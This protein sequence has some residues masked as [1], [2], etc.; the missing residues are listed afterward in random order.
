MASPNITAL[1]G[2]L[3]ARCKTLLNN[4]LK[5]ICKEE[6]LGVSGV[7]AQLQTKVMGLIETASQQNDTELLNRLRHRILNH[8]DAPPANYAAPTSPA[9]AH[10]GAS[11]AGGFN[12]ASGYR[13]NQGYSP[14]QQ[15]QVPQYH[16]R[17]SPFYEIR[18]L[19]LGEMTLEISPNHRQNINRPL[20][21]PAEMCTQLKADPTLRLLLLAGLEQPLAAYTRIDISFP[22]QVEV[23]INGDEVK[24]NFKGLKNKPGSTRP[25][26]ITDYVRKQAQY[27]NS[28]IVTYA[29]TQKKFNLY[30]YLAKK[31]SVED[32][33]AR[34]AKRNVI[35]KQT[36]ISEMRKRASDQ[37]V[38]VDSIN[39][40]LKDPI[41]TLRIT[42]PCRSNICSHN[43][44]F[45]VESFLQLQEQA[46][47]WQCPICNKTISFE[48]LAVDQYVE[49]ILENVPKGTDQVTIE[50]N[51]NWT[52]TPKNDS[53]S[54]RNGYGAADDDE[55]DYELVEII[56]DYR[57][58]AIKH[59]AMHTPKS[60]T[61]TPSTASR[62]VSTAPRAGSKRTSE[63]IDLTL[64]DDDEPVRPAKK[65]AYSTPN[66]LP[67][68]SR[69]YTLPSFGSSS[70]PMRP[71]TQAPTSNGVSS[72]ILRYDQPPPPPT[73]T[74]PPQGHAN[75]EAYA[76]PRP[77]P[78]PNYY[79]QGTQQYP[80]YLGSSP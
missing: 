40:S 16:F 59:E 27:R 2:T 74:L 11:A 80:Q 18:S 51:G 33:T 67:D 9:V 50:P 38:V 79:G 7:K 73:P 63:V 13:A 41:S 5:K 43:Q 77:P 32:L 56:S 71:Q 34:I 45:D 68:Q 6:G 36:V 42:T 55:S 21:I 12:M 8:G 17:E 24:A 23:K 30:I 66:S 47:T 4:D 61:R 54:N 3:N 28:F 57:L 26:D 31:Q 52:H 69:R 46:P 1:A 60:M 49:E 19:V 37:E 10:N 58:S 35:T 78:P 75:Y 53:Q 64:S 39:M 44:C 72:S 65:V 29:L 20:I 15:P 48:G 70:V 76:R 14:F 22:S 25:A 62:E